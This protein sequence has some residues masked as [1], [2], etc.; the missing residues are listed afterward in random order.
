MKIP[1][2]Q[3]Q[4]NI[5]PLDFNVYDENSYDICRGK[6]CMKNFCGSLR[7]H[8]MKII[9]FEKNNTL[10]IKVINDMN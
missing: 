4:V 8:A 3:K 7:E 1:P 6:D 2:Q 10:V 9:D 5:F